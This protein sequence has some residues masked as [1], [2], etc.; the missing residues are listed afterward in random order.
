MT[1]VPRTE[2][3]VFVE[4]RDDEHAILHLVMRHGLT[5]ETLSSFPWIEPSGGKEGVLEAIEAAVSAGTDRTLGF[6]LDAD[7]N[8]G[9]TWR[10]VASRLA[11]VDVQVPGEI[12]EEGFVD[13]SSRYRTRVGVWIMPD[14]E[15]PGELEDFLEG[16][17]DGGNPLLPHAQESTNHAK[18]LGAAF[19][20]AKTGKAVLHAWLAWQDNPGR[21]YGTAIKS[22]Y[23]RHD[24]EA[25]ERFVAWFRQ[26]FALDG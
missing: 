17:V 4:G 22:G 11:R 21:P 15:R 1:S 8:L 23:L 18:L 2:P 10:A 25:A 7:D 5:K 3:C 19:P 12:P 20:D 9:D 26:L 24:S 14:N 13:V 16:L 6:V